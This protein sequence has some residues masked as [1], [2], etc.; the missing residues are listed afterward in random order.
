MKCHVSCNFYFI[1]ILIIEASV[2]LAAGFLGEWCCRTCLSSNLALTL[3]LADDFRFTCS[4]SVLNIWFRYDYV[5]LAVL[6]I[7]AVCWR[8]FFPVFLNKRKRKMQ[9]DSLLVTIRARSSSLLL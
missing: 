7:I 8:G 1:F 2:P 6:L 4:K 3:T 5:C 9:L